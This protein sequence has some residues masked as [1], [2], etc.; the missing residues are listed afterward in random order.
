MMLPEK[1]SNMEC[2]M[3]CVLSNVDIESLS[4]SDI[5]GILSNVK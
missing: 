2:S 3:S 5:C 1:D 4:Y